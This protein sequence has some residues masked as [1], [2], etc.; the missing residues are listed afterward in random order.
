MALDVDCGAIV[1]RPVLPAS[2][3]SKDPAR[4]VPFAR[5]GLR[6]A[7]RGPHMPVPRQPF[8]DR[9][10]PVMVSAP[11]ERAEVCPSVYTRRRNPRRAGSRCLV[12]P[13]RAMRRAIAELPLKL[14]QTPALKKRCGKAH[15]HEV[16]SIP[17]HYQCPIARCAWGDYFLKYFGAQP[18]CGPIEPSVFRTKR[19]NLS[20]TVPTTIVARTI[21]KTHCSCHRTRTAPE[22]PIQCIF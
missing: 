10:A 9:S 16:S 1:V 17:A 21:A 19:P 22:F 3:R 5:S 7:R 6:F 8:S 4:N 18:G 11:A 13:E 2:A 12:L 15:P 20:E 14:A